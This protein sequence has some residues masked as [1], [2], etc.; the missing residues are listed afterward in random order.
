MAPVRH[1]VDGHVS[2]V[3]GFVGISAVLQQE[4]D[5]CRVPGGG[6]LVQHGGVVL[7]LRQDV[8]PC[9]E[10]KLRQKKP[11]WEFYRYITHA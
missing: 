9:I 5:D 11:Q 8:S 4:A 2:R 1:A 3:F 10:K 6:S 7:R